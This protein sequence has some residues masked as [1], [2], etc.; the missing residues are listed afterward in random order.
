MGEP[1]LNVDAIIRALHGASSQGA[2]RQQ[3][4]QLAATEIR[5][6][7]EPYTGVY[8]YML[9]GETLQLEAFAG[10]PTEHTRIAVGT[11]ICG[12]AVAEDRDLNVPD[13]T[14]AEG[15]LAC[16]AETKSELVALIR[17]DSAVLGQ[18]DID[19]DVLNGFPAEEEAAVRQVAD[20]LAA[21]L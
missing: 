4:L 18:I 13:V 6:S 12:R 11:G 19:S 2:S 15:Y 1:V 7:G 3:L 20:G 21:L 8:L 14:Q 16:T 5:A 10:R 17:R 9:H